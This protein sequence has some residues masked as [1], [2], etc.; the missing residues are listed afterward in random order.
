MIADTI[1]AI[2]TALGRGAIAV[3]RVSGPESVEIVDRLFS[4][5]EKLSLSRSH[6][7]RHGRFMDSSGRVLDEVLVAVMRAPDTYTGEDLVEISCHGGSLISRLILETLVEAGCRLAEPGEF[8][9][10]A[11]LNGRI[12][13]AQAEAV[14]ELVAA[15]TREAVEQALLQLEG[16]LSEEIS[17]VRASVLGVLSEVEARIDFPEDVPEELETG[18]LTATLERCS[19]SIKSVLS[20]RTSATLLGAGARIPIVG[21]PNVGKSSLLNAIVGSSRVIVA[22]GP[23]TTRDS[24]EQEIELGGFP[25]TLVD[26][27]GLRSATEE[28]EEEGVRRSMEQIKLA[29]LVI[30]VVDATCEDYDKDLAI[31]ETLGQRPCTVAINKIDISAPERARA[32]LGPRACSDGRAVA[33]VSAKNG[34]GIESLQG[35]LAGR[36]KGGE[37]DPYEKA[38]AGRRHLDCL[39]SSL[40]NINDA[41]DALAAGHFVELVAFELREAV[42]SLDSI[43]GKRVGAD[44]LDNIFSKFCVGK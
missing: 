30:L 35:N 36:L 38:C 15:R 31:L 3:V 17:K 14:A 19:D 24:I 41:K 25:V 43:T 23:G 22:P 13:L 12:D 37:V 39:R 5:K 27:A 21:R 33:E 40:Q 29:D 7:V 8:T 10:R 42:E 11:F 4:G 1:A 6:S 44:I 32:V 28:V 9:K 20:E 18:S 2:S 34:T 26:T 16:S